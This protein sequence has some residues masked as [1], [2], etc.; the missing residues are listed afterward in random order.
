MLF[1]SPEFIFLFLPATLASFYLLGAKRN[2]R[3]AIIFLIINSLI[4]YSW[5]KLEYLILIFSSIFV[6]YYLGFMLGKT[7]TKSVKKVILILGFIFNLGLLGYFKYFNFF[8]E[9]ANS[10]FQL[11]WSLQNIALPLGISF[12]TFQQVAYLV[13][14]YNDE[15]KDYRFLEYSLFVCFFPQLIAGPIVHHKE[16]LPQFSRLKT[17][18]FDLDELAIGLSIFSFGLFKKIVLADS[19]SVY[20]E[21]IFGAAQQGAFP[22][23]FEAWGA[24]LAYTFQLYFDFSGYSDMAI[25]LARMFRV[26]LPENF[27]SPYKAICIIDFW[28]RW[29]ITLSNFLKEYLYI[30]LGGNRKGKRRR[31]LNLFLTML[32]GGLWHGAGWTFILWGGLHG[33]FLIANNWWHEFIRRLG[34]NP[35]KPKP[36]NRVIGIIVTFV[37]IVFAWVLFRSESLQA[38]VAM[39]RGMIGLNGIMIPQAIAMKI[40]PVKELFALLGATFPEW[41]NYDL[42]MPFLWFIF[43]FP[44]VWILPNTQQWMIRFKPVLSFNK[45][46]KNSQIEQKHWLVWKINSVCGSLLGIMLF[47]VMKVALS[48]PKTEFLYFNF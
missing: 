31:D 22:S 3:L 19:I 1:T 20:V 9:T 47:V 46:E 2:L 45:Y 11:S 48:L 38:A 37:S 14:A 13:D 8:L 43:L 25:G 27:N 42:E 21:P 39:F 33:L 12:F 24:A 30:P 35:D 6:N 44:I 26:T 34:Y 15:V 40:G 23:L 10:L 28:R 17:Y 4:F 5:G 29:H 7:Q 16:I 32:L 36:L 41:S 18:A